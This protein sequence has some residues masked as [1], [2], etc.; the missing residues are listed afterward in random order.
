MGQ[1]GCGDFL[2]QFKIPGPGRSLYT[3]QVYMPCDYCQ[4]PAGVIVSRL[5][6]PEE[7]ESWDAQHLPDLPF[8]AVSN[9]HHEKFLGVADPK[10][11]AKH[12]DLEHDLIEVYRALQQPVADH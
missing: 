7:I 4:T 11:I 10:A 9:R 8:N 3:L 6:G 2:P 1:C 5:D 12:L